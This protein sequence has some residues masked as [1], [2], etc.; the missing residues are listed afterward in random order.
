LIL[1][2]VYSPDEAHKSTQLVHHLISKVFQEVEIPV[3]EYY[4]VE[5]ECSGPLQSDFPSITTSRRTKRKGVWKYL[6]TGVTCKLLKLVEKNNTKYVICDGLGV[7]RQMFLVL[8]KHPDLKLVVVVHGF[9]RFKPRDLIN[10]ISNS[11]R[12]KLVLV[13]SSLADE[14]NGCYPGLKDLVHVIPNALDPDFTGAL[15]PKTQAREALGVPVMSKLYVVASRLSSKKDVATVIKAYARLPVGDHYLV[16]MGDGPSR[17]ELECLAEE[18]GIE[19]RV[20]WLGWVKD[21]S[22]YLKAF[23]VFVSGSRSEGFGLSVFE[24]YTAGLPVVCSDIIPHREALGDRGVYFEKG[25]VAGCVRKLE[26]ACSN[27][28]DDVL[29]K[30]YQEFAKSYRAVINF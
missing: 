13:S 21:S 23:D 20:I 24:A 6:P 8:K 30:K 27:T 29:D 17:P 18:L 19:E 3:A 14:I 10:F 4:M 5:G 22:R 11:D 2:I 16:V 1:N 7:A 28:C 25:D 12:V 15:L 26:D 9:V